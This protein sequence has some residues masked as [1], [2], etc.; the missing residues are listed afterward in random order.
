MPSTRVS[1]AGTRQRAAYLRGMGRASSSDAVPLAL[2]AVPGEPFLCQCGGT[3]A[4]SSVSGEECVRATERNTKKRTVVEVSGAES[5]DLL[6][7]P[8]KNLPTRI[9]VRCTNAGG[10]QKPVLTT[11]RNDK[12]VSLYL[13]KASNWQTQELGS[14]SPFAGCSLSG[15]PAGQ[16]A[17]HRAHRP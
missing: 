16:A 11:Y 5:K 7:P 2:C 17:I 14:T 10:S 9:K 3:T 12:T 15:H 4:T 1:R 8:V 13:T 6:L